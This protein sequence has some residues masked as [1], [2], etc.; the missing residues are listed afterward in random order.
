MPQLLLFSP[1]SQIQIFAKIR[2]SLEKISLQK[3]KWLRG[4]RIKKNRDKQSVFVVEGEKIVTELIQQ[5]PDKIFLI[6]ANKNLFVE[7]EL[8]RFNNSFV[9]TESDFQKV[10]NL[11]SPPNI[12]AVVSKL[13]DKEIQTNRPIIVLDGVQDP[14]NLGT[15]IRTAD[16]FGV[17]QIVCSQN[18]VDCYNQKV[19]QA[20]MGSIFRVNICYRKLSNFLQMLEC[21]IHGAVLQGNDLNSI[22][23][24]DMRVLVLGNEGK[25]ISDEVL[26][27]ITNPV[28]IKGSG[29]AE[30]LN[31]G[32]ATGIFLHHWS[33]SII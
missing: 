27:F 12:I 7:L 28:S 18:T 29:N 23:S 13:K 4:L 24:D 3:I 11:N 2:I 15:I 9:G 8:S 17:D 5:F 25:G 32:I 1:C 33:R 31:V 20:S 14:G 30:S 19:I 10:A 6:L 26:P 22:P 21:Q 16:W